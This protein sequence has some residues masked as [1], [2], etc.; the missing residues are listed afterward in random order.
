MKSP[1][2]IFLVALLLLLLSA[3]GSPASTRAVACA[4]GSYDEEIT[5]GGAVRQY[6]L[7]I[8]ASYERGTPVPLLIGFHG[9]GSTGARFESY[10]GFSSLADR[11]GF[12]AVYPQGL[13][14]PAE[15]FS[16]WDTMPG[17][18]DVPVIRDLIDSLASRCDIDP[19][20]IYA[21]GH[22]RGGGM[23][24]RLGCEL[25]DRIAA[26]GPVS[27]D[28]GF[29]E[30]CSP[31]RPVPVIAFHGILDPAIPYNGFGLPGQ[32]HQSYV[33]L[34]VPVPGWTADWATRNGC[35]GLSS[36]VFQFGPVSGN[37]W[38]NCPDSAEVVLYTI[39][40]GTHDWPT[41]VDA[42]QMIWEFFSRHPLPH[43]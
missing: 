34:G 22:S 7:Y 42:S 30:N 33:S 15:G 27:G 1:R 5:S 38:S 43:K 3:C 16:N 14:D 29:S 32:I 26:I 8:P 13:T 9:A 11:F 23:V 24:N 17:S 4:P 2:P 12:I 21:S 37:G 40:D 6:G 36:M 28:Y 35:V 20:R 41:A 39:Q 10:S 19:D 18:T 31:S 25:A